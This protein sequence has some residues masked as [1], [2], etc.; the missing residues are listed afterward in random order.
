MRGPTTLAFATAAYL[1]GRS[2]AVPLP[3]VIVT[4][5]TANDIVISSK[6]TVNA[7]APAPSGSLST[8][9]Q[10]I[11][12]PGDAKDIVLT[13]KNTLNA[14]TPLSDFVRRSGGQLPLALV[15]NFAGSVNAYV[16]GLDANGLL[17]MLQPDGTFY[18]PT[19]TSSQT[20]PQLI[21][22][23]VA[24][25]LGA[26]G[27]TTSITIPGYISSARVWFAAG[28]LKFFTV[29]NPATNA[30][31]LVEPASVNPSDPSASVN[32]GFIELTYT[33]DGGLFANISYVDFVG[34]I[35][36]MSLAVTDGTGTQSALGLSAGAVSSICSALET[37]GQSD[38]EAWGDL[39]MADSSG[40]L[41]RVIAPPDYLSSNSGAFSTFWNTYID[42]VWTQFTTDTLSIDT[43]MSAGVVDC[44]VETDGLLHCAGD[45][46]GYAKPV[47]ADIFGC[48]SGP[49][50]IES[51]DNDIHSAV[52]PR[53]CA[54]FDR[55]TLTLD[56]GNTQ[57]GLAASNYY[58]NAPTNWYSKFVHQYEVDGKGYA[59]S[60]DDVTPDD[61]VNQSGVV[62]SA[63]PETLTVIVG[64]PLS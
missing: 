58:L 6:N 45:N 26:Q 24:I 10:T 16:T 11:V 47:A 5:G 64:G 30:P 32:W 25:P 53:L 54:A 8:K 1:I 44:T 60:Y 21:T 57:P 50:S 22:A 59:F 28:D 9:R 31:S 19:C 15:N 2:L 29:W 12:T 7:T 43:Q 3:A 46:R 42:D 52:V 14:T 49:F 27:S 36:G 63:N 41:L 18:Y 34:L 51:G 55:S 40:N 56:G 23:N 17:V 20:T 13:A 62:A 39:C 48:N 35:L 4:P 33:E 38:G 37:Q 61:G